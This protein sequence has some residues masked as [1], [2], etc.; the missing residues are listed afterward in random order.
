VDDLMEVSRIGRGK[1]SLERAP[2]DLA[3]VVATAVETSR[4]L[5]E[6]HRHT[7]TISLP[8][9]PAR[10]EADSARLAQ[11]LSNLLNNAAK[12]TEDGG[13][14]DLIVEQAQ[15][16]AVIRVRDNGIGIA[17][18]RMP[19]IFDMFEQIEGA[20]DRSQGGLGIGLTLARRLIEMQGG[21][22]EAH[23]PGLGKGSEFVTR[24][25]ALAEPATEPAP[26]PAEGL[27]APSANG[28]RRVLVVDDNVDS[29]ESMAVLLRLYGHE[30][31]LAHDGEAALKEARAFKPDVMFL[32]LSLPKMDGYEV[33]RRLRLEP[34]MSGMTLVAMTGYGHEEERRRT[35]EAGFHLH[36]VK[37]VDL[38]MLKDLLSSLPA[39]QFRNERARNELGRGKAN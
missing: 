8:E 10:V 33:A 15:G 35:R 9:R 23:S 12:Y 25:P 27:P 14:I 30:V 22:I 21:K 31:R 20:A 17:P 5:V 19:S 34:A 28:P 18:E 13:R 6:A 38:D 7:L 2:V 4:P 24:L 37:P 32:D 29:A 1:I 36:L 11:V 3:D 39:N 16:E 26:E